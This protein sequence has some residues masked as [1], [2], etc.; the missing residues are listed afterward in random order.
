MER[1]QEIR[2]DLSVVIQAIERWMIM[3]QKGAKVW[4]L[5]SGHEVTRKAGAAISARLP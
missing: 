1:R 3:S 4:F 5:T 2:N